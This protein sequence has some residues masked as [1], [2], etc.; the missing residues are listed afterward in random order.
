[1]VNKEVV[2]YSLRNL[3]NRKTRSL[4]TLFSIMMGIMM[5]F[6][7][8]SF[9]L[10]LYHY[11][12]EI[13]SASSADKIIVQPKGV[14]GVGLDRTFSFNDDDLNAVKKT[15]GVYDATGIYFR[16]VEVKQNKKLFYTYLFG[17]DPDK[18]FLMDTYNIGVL[19]G[20]ELKA[21]DSGVILGYNYL[22]KDTIFPK[23]YSLNSNIEIN[24]DKY[25]VLG[26]YEAVGN[27]QDDA[28]IYATNDVLKKI[29]GEDI[30]YNW[31]IAKADTSKL[32][33]VVKDIEKNLRDERG[34]EEGKEDFY[35]Q[36]Y[37]SLI[38]SYSNILDIVI[39]FI[40]LIAL[41]SVLVSAVNTAN[42]M[43]TSVL[44]RVKEI[45]IIKSIGGTNSEVFGIF[46]FESLFLGFIAGIIGVLFG[47]IFSFI[48]GEILSSLGYSFLAPYFPV[49]L[50]VG[51]VLFA[52]MTGAISGVVPAIHAMKINPI[53]ALRYE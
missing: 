19:K 9:G 2:N 17:Y 47:W 1:M 7:F 14:G 44:E 23:A 45:G 36:T 40:V 50:F 39:G 12:D 38:E 48:G 53:K 30:P 52:V 37:D 29:F 28:Q 34:Q 51:C 24:G 31:L 43:I 46:L 27:P 41:I 25:R 10:G 35:V 16:V 42:T 4:F 32:D 11:I 26:F 6:I 33:K 15:S 8:V 21:G 18:P 22:I 5:I 13:T 20:R 3:K 49:E